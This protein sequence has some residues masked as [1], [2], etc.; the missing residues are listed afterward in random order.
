[1][2]VRVS[3][4]FVSFGF[5]PPSVIPVHYSWGA[6]RVRCWRCW[7]LALLLIA[8]P[9]LEIVSANVAFVFIVVSS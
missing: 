1:M 5:L 9:L 4:P 3:Y 7:H 2:T 8:K 6:S